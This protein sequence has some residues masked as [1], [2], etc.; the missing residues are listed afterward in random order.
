MLQKVYWQVYSKLT[1]DY[2]GTRGRWGKKWTKKK[3]PTTYTLHW[4][5]SVNDEKMYNLL[6]WPD[7]F[8]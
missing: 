5:L 3:L 8:V 6:P 2:L 7:A 1:Q 4:V